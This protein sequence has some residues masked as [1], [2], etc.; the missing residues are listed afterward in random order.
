MISVVARRRKPVSRPTRIER[1]DET[2]QGQQPPGRTDRLDVSAAVALVRRRW[3]QILGIVVVAGL[4][5]YGVSLLQATRYDASAELLFKKADYAQ[6]LFG[7]SSTSGS[8]DPQREAATDLA[9]SSLQV[10]TA[11][12]KAVLHSPLTVDQL[13]KRVDVS[14]IGEADIVTIT[15]HAGTRPEAVRIANVFASQ[16][17]ALRREAA[18]AQVQSAIDSLR[19][20]AQTGAGLAGLPGVSLA[21]Q[22]AKLETLKA[23]QTG[24]VEVVQPATPPLRRAAPTPA[25]NGAIGAGAGLILGILAMLL[26]DRTDRRIRRSDD[27]AEL[28]GVPLL[29]SLPYDKSLKSGR[30]APAEADQFFEAFHFLRANLQL[31]ELSLEGRVIAVSSPLPGDGK[32]TVAAGL[33]RSL[34]ESGARVI[35]VD[36]DLRKPM[37]GSAF[38]LGPSEGLS[39]VLVGSH[40][41]VG[42]LRETDE[43]RLSVLMAGA[44]PVSPTIALSVRNLREIITTLMT[45]ADYVILDAPP[46]QVAA[47]ASSLAAVADGVLLVIDI[48]CA[49]RDIL[50]ATRRQLDHAQA[51]VFGIVANRVAGG[52]DGGGYYYGHYYEQR[53]G[54]R[55]R[56]GIGVGR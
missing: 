40:D 22:L 20:D 23:L 18:Q 53:N 10:V 9:L 48:A 37:L 30:R 19:T 11:R 44:T 42:L 54:R 26:L 56:P 28:F 47:E 24:N 41:P 27:V 36:G 2:M 5:A 43:E 33:A 15:A 38:G 4:L 49:T 8:T 16:V 46:I 34:A 3:W 35:A 31:Q 52:E 14:P 6:T 17:V 51:R 7:S 39:D 29:A 1:E 50:L 13:R 45:E 25:R 55:R 12:T 32:T 21:D